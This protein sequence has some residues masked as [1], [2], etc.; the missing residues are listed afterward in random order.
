MR[1]LHSLLPALVKIRQ[2]SANSRWEI[3]GEPFPKLTPVINFLSFAS[4]NTLERA[5]MQKIN[6]YG[7]S[8]SPWRSPL[9]GLKNP[10]GEPLIRTTLVGVP[11]H[12]YMK[13]I[14][15]F[16]DFD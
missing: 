12:W 15:F 4:F 14:Q 7:E 11:I 5:S 2:S 10:V 16:H 6:R 9:V 13:S 3:E 1:F 8:G